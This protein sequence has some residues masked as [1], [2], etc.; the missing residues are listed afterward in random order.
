MPNVN[1]NFAG[2]TL[3]I[4]NAYYVDNVNLAFQAAPPTTPPLVFIGYAYGIK[5]QTP[6]TFA[7]G[8]SLTRA[9]R[10][11][12]AAAYVPFLMTPSPQ[13][14]GAQ[15]ITFINVGENTQSSLS[16][17]NAG[18]SGIALLTSANYGLPSNLL[19]AQ[20]V[21]GSLAGKKV[22]LYDGY[23]ATTVVGDNLGV[24]FV[25][26]YTGTATGTVNFTVTV[27][28][29]NAINFATSSPNAGESLSIALGSGN[30]STIGQIVQYLNGSGF[31]SAIV[32][33]DSSLPSNY[34]D[35]G[36]SSVTLTASG[37]GG[38]VYSNV[39][40]ALGSVVYW[41]NQYA[42]S[43]A[44]AAI[45]G[46]ISS[47]TSGL[48]PAN[49]PFTS[50]TGATSVPPTN[51]DYANAFNLALTVPG[52]AVF[53]DSNTP[54]VQSLGSQHAITASTPTGAGWRRFYTGSSTGDSVNT[55][56][57]NAQGLGSNRT[58]YAYPGIY[59]INPSTGVNTLYGGLYAA[60]AAAGMSTGNVIAT[61]LTNKVLTGTGVEV[62][63]TTTQINQLQ[64][65]GVM[66]IR[67]ST[68]PVSGSVNVANVPPTVVS[69][70]TT[71]QVDNNPENVFEQ[72][73]KCR[74]WLA[75]SMTNALAPYVGTIA[76]PYDEARMLNAAKQTLNGL[77]YTPGSNGILVSW[78]PTKLF[79]TYTGSTQT[80]AISANV[81]LVGQNRFITET[82]V[83]SPLNLTISAA[84]LQ[85]AA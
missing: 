73:M 18:G 68:P 24:P 76:D 64:Q 36:Q 54:A 21:A 3:I 44:T 30:Y 29:L 79:L 32:Y 82:V 9:L 7:D 59:N 49:I 58:I 26:A 8:G 80:A 56:I 19:Q 62:Q 74:D 33:G 65:A 27:S 78:D 46:S 28:G 85:P 60:A 71:W 67:G 16:L 45:S 55:T 50:F 63:L 84:A 48:A 11:G 13:L 31:Y 81:V 14:F 38:Y 15:L 70:L 35:S 41:T 17:K 10:G 23:T 4:P 2:Q 69:D 5:P 75:Y 22:T 61:P 40:A 42:S 20:V 83:I 66:C 39:T 51:T 72:Q 52:W 77:I 57:A 12:P 53:C 34:L 25:L 43:Y 47:L 1:V 37:S 6:V